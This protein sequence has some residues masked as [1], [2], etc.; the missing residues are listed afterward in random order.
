MSRDGGEIAPI[1]LDPP[2]VV[3]CANA[4][5]WTRSPD[6]KSILFTSGHHAYVKW[7]WDTGSLSGERET[8]LTVS[9]GCLALVTAP[10]SET[11]GPRRA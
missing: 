4:D 5:I 1:F 9:M 7:T 10:S 8:D 11:I 2:G 6:G 3:C